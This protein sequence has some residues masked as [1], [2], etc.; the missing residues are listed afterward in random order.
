MRANYH[1]GLHGLMT[2]VRVLPEDLYT[3]VM[4]SKEDIPQGGDLRGDRPPQRQ[5]GRLT[6][7]RVRIGS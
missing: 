7:G 4:E 3:R 6:S 5:E 2:V 1:M